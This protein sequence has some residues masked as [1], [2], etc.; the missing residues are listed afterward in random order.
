MYI[1][2]V[3]NKH[4]IKSLCPIAD[5]SSKE[6]PLLDVTTLGAAFHGVNNSLS[7]PKS[8]TSTHSRQNINKL[9]SSP[10]RHDTA[11]YGSVPNVAYV[12]TI[13]STVSQ[14]VSQSHTH[15]MHGR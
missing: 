8:N 3:F 7:T 4:K 2:I 6:S 14:L 9:Q 5:R 1:I 11:Q 13:K 10:K 15:P 12:L